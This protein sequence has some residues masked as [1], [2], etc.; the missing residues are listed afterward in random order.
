VYGGENSSHNLVK[1]TYREH[2]IAHKLLCKIFPDNKSL[3]YAFLCMIRDPYGYRNFSSRQVDNIKVSFS[4]FRSKELKVNNPMFTEKARKVHSDR[5]K[6]S[7]PTRNNPSCNRTAQ[8]IE[9]YY[10]N[11]SIEKYTYAKELTIIKNIPYGTVKHMLK[12]SVG[13]KKH[14]VLKLVRL[15]K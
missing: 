6:I 7:N 9:V 5:M 3:N 2:F 10:I 8:P 14:G 4:K 13:C 1:L 11:G 12:Y 15:E